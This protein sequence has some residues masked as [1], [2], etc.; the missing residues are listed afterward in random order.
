MY[1]VD[2]HETA[3][4]QESR[5]RAKVRPTQRQHGCRTPKRFAHTE[6]TSSGR[7]FLPSAL[8]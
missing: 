7:K 2:D 4:G 3:V 8:G 5:F 1:S 6:I